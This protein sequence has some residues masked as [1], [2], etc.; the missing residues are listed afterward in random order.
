M[1]EI[2]VPKVE[3]ASINVDVRWLARFFHKYLGNY[4]HEIVRFDV[5]MNLRDKS[6]FM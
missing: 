5:K 1:S 6:V 4:S 3:E 2:E